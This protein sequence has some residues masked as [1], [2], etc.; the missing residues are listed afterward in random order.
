[1]RTKKKLYK[2]YTTNLARDMSTQIEE[3]ENSILNLQDELALAE[4]CWVWKWS[5]KKLPN[6]V[7]HIL[8]KRNMALRGNRF[9][10]K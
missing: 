6:G 4:K 1:M 7:A 8:I 10:L 2:G 5:Q 9:I 3:F